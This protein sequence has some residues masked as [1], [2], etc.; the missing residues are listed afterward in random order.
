MEVKPPRFA[1]MVVRWLLPPACVEHVLGDL[2]E[3]MQGVEPRA[4]RR[5]YVLDAICTVPP[6]IFSRLFRSLDL[7]LACLYLVIQYAAF[8]GM[9]LLNLHRHGV[10]LTVNSLIEFWWFTLAIVVSKL[11]SDA[12]RVLGVLHVAFFVY[13][14]WY[15]SWSA[16]PLPAL[17]DG[18]SLGYPW[19]IVARWLFEEYSSGPRNR[20]TS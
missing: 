16:G 4:A 9:G 7:R 13:I 17:M 20:R 12:Y 2:Q 14:I 19:L 6:V 3:R 10:Q 18:F 8:L 11:I 15:V 5:Q 1:E